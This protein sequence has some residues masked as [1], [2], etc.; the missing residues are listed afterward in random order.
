MGFTQYTPWAPTVLDDVLYAE[1]LADN[2]MRNNPLVNATVG[3][4]LTRW[5][6]NY[7][8]PDGNKKALAWIGDLSPNDLNLN[9]PQRAFVVLRDDP[10]TSQFA[11]AVYDHSPVLGVPLNQTIHLQSIDSQTILTESRSG[12]VFFP[13]VQIPMG[14]TD[15]FYTQFPQT[16]NTASYQQLM[17]GRMSGSGTQVHYRIWGLTD[18]G[19]TANMRVRVTDNFSNTFISPVYP[20][21]SGGSVVQDASMDIT[22][23]R[24]VPDFNIYVEAQVTSG[25]GKVYVTTAAMSNY[26][27]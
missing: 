15:G 6:G 23:L 13:R 18:V 12:G 16:N 8:G 17:E 4:G 14:R 2:I 24:G 27:P 7:V 22:A 11:F 26:S 25:T 21:A 9:R 19:T 10:G 1:N 20:I 3:T 5:L